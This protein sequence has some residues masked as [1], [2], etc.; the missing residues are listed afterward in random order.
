MPKEIE[1]KPCPFCGSK[2]NVTYIPNDTG[3]KTINIEC[4][5]SKCGVV[6]F[7]RLNFVSDDYVIEAWNRRV[8][9]E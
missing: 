5:N 2:P 4:D 1:L 3:G 8:E 6:L 7:T 9:N